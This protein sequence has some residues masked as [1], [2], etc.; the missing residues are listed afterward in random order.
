MK[1]PLVSGLLSRYAGLGTRSAAER[2][3][4]WPSPPRHPLGHP[5]LGLRNRWYLVCPAAELGG[6][7]KDLRLLGEDLVLWRDGGGAP[8]LM[9]DYCPHR[10]A[11][12]SLG[13]VVDGDLQCWYHSWRYDGSGQCTSVPSQGGTCAL[14]RRT[15]VTPTY[16]T[17]EEAGY[18]WAW[19]GEDEPAPLELPEEFHDPSYATFAETVV[20][21]A[22]WL[23]IL[24]N[25]TDL[26]HAPFLHGRSLTLSRGVT[27]DRIKVVE[28]DEGFRVER[29]G[30]QGV[31]FD[32]TEVSTGALPWARLDIPYPSPWVAGPGPALRIVSFVTPVDETRTIVNFP[33]FRRVS[34][35]QR[36]LWQL[37]YRLR[38]R[39]TH[40]HVLNQ[41][42]TMLEALGSIERATADEHMAQADRAVL[43]LR[44]ALL[45]A[46][47]EQLR[48]HGIEPDG[49]VLPIGTGD[50]GVGRPQV[51][52]GDR[53]R[54][55]GGQAS[56]P[57]AQA[58]EGRGPESA[59]RG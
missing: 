12:L 49:P 29:K 14:Q 37:L 46:F 13:D 36:T 47:D 26:M 6:E 27:E 2:R 39:G 44:K 58:S 41:D 15:R 21:D 9:N 57:R 48:R 32:W 50:A 30:Q 53:D 38:L 19:I 10:G 25:L 51:A 20:W 55:L 11:R 3:S 7:P 16:P 34:G 59:A 54:D 42:K 24:E 33:R 8:H 43:H 17:H 40:L 31:N 56:D 23:L 1:Q 5:H 4:N 52:D 28:T 22:S 45:P 35:W 18:V